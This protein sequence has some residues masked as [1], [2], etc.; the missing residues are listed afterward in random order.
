MPKIAIDVRPLQDGSR[1]RG[2]G[3]MIRHMLPFFAQYPEV[4]LLA[5]ETGPVFDNLG[6][7]VITFPVPFGLSITNTSSA[8]GKA[9]A[10]FLR[11]HDVTLVHFMAQYLVPS[12]LGFPFTVL[13]HDLFNRHRCVNSAK[14]EKEVQQLGMR[15][16]PAKAWMAVSEFTKQEM[17]SR[18]GLDAD[19]ISIVNPAM[20]TSLMG[21]APDESVFLAKKIKK[22]YILSV[23][24]FEARKNQ[25][26]MIEAFLQM[27][28]RL[29]RAYQYV[30]CIGQGTM[31]P[32]PIRLQLLLKN[33]FNEFRFLNHVTPT[34][35][36]A[37]YQNA[38][39]LS[40][41][42]K[43]EGF[44]LPLLEGLYFGIPVVTSSATSLPE[45]GQDAAA[46]ADPY[47]VDDMATTLAEV[48]TDQSWVVSH[49]AAATKVLAGF[50]FEKAVRET[51]TSLLKT[52]P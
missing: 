4:V 43:A 36:V 10:V 45:V 22:P 5:A 31:V 37:L 51:M 47:S 39:A 2:I 32:L 35:L 46:Y 42:S 1:F 7:P 15:L 41:I 49:Q 20:P 6:I 24:D 29:G 21:L 48:V 25:S 33:R 40:F 50:S 27:N 16:A 44:G 3:M 9:L 17:V 14:D 23:G 26:G 30:A 11:D 13:V 34:E 52:L 38:S 19:L 28:D 18:L 12:G 8:F